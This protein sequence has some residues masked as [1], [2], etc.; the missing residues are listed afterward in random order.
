MASRFDTAKNTLG[1]CV[2]ADAAIG[3]LLKS[4]E[5]L[6]LNWLL[7]TTNLLLLPL[8]AEMRLMAMMAASG[9][10]LLVVESCP[11]NSTRQLG[12]HGLH[13][14]CLISTTN[15]P[16]SHHISIEPSTVQFACKQETRGAAYDSTVPPDPPRTVKV[17]LALST[18]GQGPR[19]YQNACRESRIPSCRVSIKIMASG[20]SSGHGEQTAFSEL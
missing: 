13:W 2:S 10:L 18:P 7:G 14:Y 5:G 4:P 12:K 9:C 19:F 15:G 1:P 6:L 20:K 8:L 3:S 16:P 11:C 17:P